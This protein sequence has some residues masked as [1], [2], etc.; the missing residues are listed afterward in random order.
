VSGHIPSR[1]AA[2]AG[3]TAAAAASA[4]HESISVG[5]TGAGAA[6]TGASSFF[7]GACFASG[8]GSPVGS[9][10]D[11]QP[12]AMIQTLQTLHTTCLMSQVRIVHSSTRRRITSRSLLS[13]PESRFKNS[14]PTPSG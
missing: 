11:E 6:V 1:I 4:S 3:C 14:M 10:A 8:S 5:T 13:P 12:A 2:S 7:T 9:G